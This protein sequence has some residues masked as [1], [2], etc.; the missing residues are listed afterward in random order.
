MHLK[1]NTLRFKIS[2]LAILI[3]AFVLVVYSMLLFF[4]IRHTLYMEL[5]DDLRAKA[6]KI[7]NAVVSYLNVLGDDQQSFVF[8]VRRVISQTGSHPHEN[9]IEKLEQLWLGQSQPLKLDSDYVLFFDPLGAPLAR[10]RNLKVDYRLVPVKDIRSALRGRVVFINFRRG[11][12]H[13]RAILVPV[14]YKNRL[15]EKRY[16]L[17]VATSRE[18]ILL[19]MKKRLIFKTVSVLLILTIA[20]FLSDRFVRRALKP[21]QEIT[22]AAKEIDYKDLSMRLSTEGIDEEMKDLVDALNQMMSRLERS[23]KYIAEFSSHVSHELKTPLAILRGE[24]ELALKSKHS[25]EEYRSMIKSNLEEIDRMTKIVND[26]L[27]LTKLDYQPE[28]FNFE[29]FD[30]ADFFKEMADSA[31]ILADAKD[32]RVTQDMADGKHVQLY[33]DQAHLRRLFFNLINNAV[34]FTP[35]GGTIGLRAGLEG[36]Y[37]LISV[38]DTGVG[39]SESNLSKIFEKFFHTEDETAS[40]PGN[41][42]GLSIAQAV[43]RIHD[44]DIQVKSAVG[45]GSIFTVRLPL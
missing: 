5:D 26:L 33:G 15:S 4:S 30:L 12:E 2:V 22:R 31:K 44:G 1:T 23:F 9:K 20:S 19:I 45:A 14:S 6:Q 41:G 29:S 34:K 18:R 35:A 36:K 38:S 16:A 37:A 27:L 39:I 13:L 42:L 40:V 7:N 11:K 10:S 24:S 43:A 17:L 21:V 3:L 32:V 8:S 28:V 25:S